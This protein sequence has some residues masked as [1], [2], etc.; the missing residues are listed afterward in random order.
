MTRANK[1]FAWTGLLA[2]AFALRVGFAVGSPNIFFPDEIFQTLE[3]AHRLAFGYGVISWEWRLGDSL[4]GLSNI[5]CRSHARDSLDGRGIERLPAWNQDRSV[6]ALAGGNLVRIRMGQACRRPPAAIIA[7][8]ACSFFFG[9]VYFA[10]RAMN[11]VVA[12]HVMLPGLYLGVYGEKL[13][14]QEADVSCRLSLRA[15]L[16]A[17]GCNYC[18]RFCLQW[19]T[20][21]IHAG[22]RE[23]PS[24]PREHRFRCFSSGPWIG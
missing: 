22:A 20:S 1:V 8:L 14:E 6:A 2:S 12:T 10:P 4:L 17:C 11:E 15:W 13:G 16:P 9:L 7:A 18:P 21:A 5:P 19:F 23:F 3:P 24:S